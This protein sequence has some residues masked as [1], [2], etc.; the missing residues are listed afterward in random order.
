MKSSVANYLIHSCKSMMHYGLIAKG[1]QSSISISLLCKKY[2]LLF[3]LLCSLY[4]NKPA[5][6][7]IVT[8][9]HISTIPFAPVVVSAEGRAAACSR[10][11]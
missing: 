2:Q 8:V 1:A 4:S 11:T 6:S 5:A 7:H 3:H 9:G 10:G